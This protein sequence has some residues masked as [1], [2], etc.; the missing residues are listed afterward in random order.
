M[1]LLLNSTKLMDLDAPPLARLRP[2]VPVFQG[3]AEVLVNGLRGLSGRRWQQA[4]DVSDRLADT[5]RG[6]LARW[7]A[8]D[9]PGRPAWYAFTGLLYQA[10]D[11]RTL[12]AAARRRARSRLRILSGLYGLL[13]PFD[14]VEAY[15]L[16]M[17][18]RWA[19][20]RTAHMTAFWRERLTEAVNVQLCDGEAVLTV[21]SQEYMKALDTSRLRGP[22][23]APVFKETRPDGSLKTAPVHAKRARGAILRHALVNGARHPRDL[24][25]FDAMGWEATEEPPSTG[26]WLFTR[27]ARD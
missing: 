24:L 13:G 16:E 9:N 7:G 26:P 8:R 11:P 10:L 25:D 2:S 5:A 18:C 17:G 6:E 3:T 22:V 20:G 4:M 14:V 19:P 27:P 1:L 15:R 23:V 21:A 12:D